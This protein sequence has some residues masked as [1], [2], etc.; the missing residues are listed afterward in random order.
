MK[1][2]RNSAK[3]LILKDGR[4][5]CTRNVGYRGDHYYLLPGGGQDFGETLTD[6]LR[7]ECLE[8][9]GAHVIVHELR[10]VRDYI[11]KNHEFAERYSEFH[12]IEYMFICSLANEPGVTSASNP[13]S[14]QIGVEWIELEN[15][16][17]TPIFPKALK[18]LIG[19]DGVLTGSVYLGDVN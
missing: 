1:P 12:Q 7:R 2:I 3:A 4:L 6:A 14:A 11:G 18:E 8:E 13:D 10:Y 5:L 17:H 15:L 16:R 19:T 9:I